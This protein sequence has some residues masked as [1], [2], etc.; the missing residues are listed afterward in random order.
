MKN[1]ENGVPM[2]NFVERIWKWYIIYF[3]RVA[4]EYK[5]II[6]FLVLC[7][8]IWLLFSISRKQVSLRKA[9]VVELLFGYLLFVLMSTVFARESM[10]ATQANLDIIHA[11]RYKLKYNIDTQFELL[12]N[13]LLLLP[14]GVMFPYI[15]KTKKVAYTLSSGFMLIM[16]IEGL[17]FVLKKGTFELTDIINNSFGVLLGCL[18]YIFVRKC[19]AI[20][21]I[22]NKKENNHV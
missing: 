1:R 13:V 19:K 16:L 9:I 20:M 18:I 14:Y 15:V 21:K 5:V 4:T 12:L 10:D 7:M 17:Q 8:G 3:E 6:L 11:Y 2:R 22:H